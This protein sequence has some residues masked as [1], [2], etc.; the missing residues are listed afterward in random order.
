MEIILLFS[1]LS[2][3][4]ANLP[5]PSSTSDPAMA[6]YLTK[7]WSGYHRALEIREEQMPV[8]NYNKDI[9][10]FNVC[11][12]IFGIYLQKIFFRITHLMII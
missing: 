1:L 3:A 8:M 2:Y 5:L 6:K 11:I 7:M 4:A 10:I 12:A 9:V